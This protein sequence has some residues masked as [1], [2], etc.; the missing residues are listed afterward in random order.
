MADL[1]VKDYELLDTVDEAVA[2][3]VV[4]FDMG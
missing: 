2:K 3:L 1:G 4:D